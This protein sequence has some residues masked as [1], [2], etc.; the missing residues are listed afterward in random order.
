MVLL[1]KKF[2]S[3][4][5]I[6][7]DSLVKSLTGKVRGKTSIF[8]EAEEFFQNQPLDIKKLNDLAADIEQL[9]IELKA[10][11]IFK[12]KPKEKVLE[13]EKLETAL[14]KEKQNQNQAR[15]NRLNNAIGWC[16][17][18]LALT[19][20]SDFEE[21]QLKSSKF[22]ATI[23]LFS[24]GEGKRLSELHYQLTPAYKAVLSLR[25]LDKLVLGGVVKNKYI[26]T[27]YSAESRYEL[28]APNKLGLTQS[29]LLP[30]IF[31][32]I[33]QEIGAMHPKVSYFLGGDHG[34]KDRFRTL[35]T[36]ERDK[37]KKL[38]Y[39]Y[40]QDYLQNGLGVQRGIVNS[41]E[42]KKQF[43][44]AEEQRLKFQL[45][46][47][48]EA[49][50][51]TFGTSEIIRIPQLYSSIVLSTK[52]TFSRQSL[53]NASVLISKLASKNKI[54]SQAAKA[55]VSIVGKFPLGYGIVYIPRDMRGIEL[56]H[57]EYAIVTSL[58]PSKLD[59][60]NCRLVTRNLLY[61]EYGKTETIERSRNLHYAF[62]R[63]KLDR[64]DPA[65][66]LQIRQKLTHQFDPDNA[67]E[68][69]PSY[70]EANHFFFNEGYQKLW[71][72]VIQEDK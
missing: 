2:N 43:V 5:T 54:S 39:E 27:N 37:I 53:P 49:S 58:N 32:A 45:S 56:S 19:E 72:Q 35:D 9:K 16:L 63:K 17:R 18:L 29:V 38:I 50:V 41:A 23:L 24:P 71:N 70:W 34:E 14:K 22:L 46:L 7:L 8:Q 65:K 13:L 52:R 21:T 66:L 64:V 67:E 42:E 28:E 59:E 20:G 25:L 6:A 4:Y 36:L 62:A 68:L 31:T 26:Q 60:P 30:V 33:F 12:F 11:P 61:S 10:T 3:N 57:Y 51:H 1:D 48:K 55:F 47:V 15:L 44:D 40:T 69:I